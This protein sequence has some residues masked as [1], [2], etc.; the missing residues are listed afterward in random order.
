MKHTILTLVLITMVSFGA[1]AQRYGRRVVVPPPR[2]V[3]RPVSPPPRRVVY[4]QAP[5]YVAPAPVYVVSRPA[6]IAPPPMY[7]RRHHHHG[8]NR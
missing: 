2:V 4:T 6:Y 3:Y 8:C 7:Y 5:V 1:A